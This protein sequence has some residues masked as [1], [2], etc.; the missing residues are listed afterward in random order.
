[1]HSQNSNILKKASLTQRSFIPKKEGV[2]YK[3]LTRLQTLLK[4]T[5]ADYNCHSRESSIERSYS[6]I[7]SNT[8]EKERS[9]FDLRRMQR[10][11]ID[12]IFDEQ[13]TRSTP[14][15]NLSSLYLN[16]NQTT[17]LDSGRLEGVSRSKNKLQKRIDVNKSTINES[18]LCSN[19]HAGSESKVSLPFDKYFMGGDC[20]S[21]ITHD[22]QMLE[23]N[24]SLMRKIKELS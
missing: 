12:K 20:N 21:N 3:K 22:S 14:I 13:S 15:G 8:R 19:Q 16:S 11:S 6:K 4:P 18:R 2:F 23:M 17:T 5:N 9:T 10:A 7:R 24:F 1:M